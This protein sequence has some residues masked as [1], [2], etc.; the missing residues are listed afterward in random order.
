M[1]VRTSI[2]VTALILAGGQG[3]R[4]GGR[5]KALLRVGGEQLI[6][7]VAGV[8][9]PRVTRLLVSVAEPA[10]WTE[11]PT[12]VDEQ[13]G[14]G[15]LSGIAAG[16]SRAPGWLLVVA[17]DMPHLRGDVLDL[18]LA[19]AASGCD[20]VAFRLGGLPEP[21]VALW[22][23]ACAPVVQRRLAAGQR[24]VADALLDPEVHVA[25][26]DEPEVRALD[27]QLRT[28]CNVNDADDVAAL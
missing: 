24:K 6:D 21:L 20:A 8:L 2:D 19:R 23:P 17:V 25:W 26:I 3:L 1:P 11:L 5:N 9:R 7:R 22:G 14:Q 12:V 10:S 15:P 16:L 4:L 27:P 18:L 28:F 13:T